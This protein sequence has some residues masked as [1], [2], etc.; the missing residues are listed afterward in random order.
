VDLKVINVDCH[1]RLA[2]ADKCCGELSVTWLP[3][4]YKKIKFGSHENVGWGEIHLPESTMHTSAYWIEFAE[5]AA[6]RS[7]LGEKELGESLHALANTLRQVA[8]VQV[9]CDV[10]DIRAHAM[11]RAPFSDRPTVYLYEIYPGG[12]GFSNKLY[13]HHNRLLDA[14]ISLLKQC[15]CKEG[16]PSCV[17]PALEIGQ[18]GKNGAL[19]LALLARM[20]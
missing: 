19:K 1:E 2:Q 15:A 5:D 4:M 17:G 11:L 20:E 10:M 7:E 14:A 6:E 18:H 12:V 13:T 3:T 8:P 16:C 9:L